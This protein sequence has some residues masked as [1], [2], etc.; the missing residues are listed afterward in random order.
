VTPLEPAP[1]ALAG[2]RRLYLK[3]EDTHVLGAFKWRGA[4]PVLERFRA[5]GATAV[6]TASTGNHGAATAWAAQQ[7]GLEAV[8]F[9]PEGASRTKLDHLQRLGANLRLAGLDLDEAKEVGRAHAAERDLPFFEDG[10]EP[11]QYE[12][13]AAIGDELIDQLDEPP[14]AVV[15][16]W[17]T[18]R[19]SAASAAHCC[20]ARPPR[21]ASASSPR[22]RR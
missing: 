20:G 12:G 10:A 17:G 21:C 3:R 2:D 19:C 8:V 5:E 15:V 14:A 11:A 13:Y 18:G 6:V 4:L 16:R 22:P 9:A 1:A 7:L